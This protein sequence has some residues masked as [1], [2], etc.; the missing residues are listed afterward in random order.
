VAAVHTHSFGCRY[1][2]IVSVD[3]CFKLPHN[4]QTVVTHKVLKF[5]TSLQLLLM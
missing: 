5:T 2:D 3:I 4:S 1:L